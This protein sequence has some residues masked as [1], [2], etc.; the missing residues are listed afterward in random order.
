MLRI[1]PNI[2]TW[3]G[4]LDHAQGD[5]RVPPVIQSP[6]CQTSWLEAQQ[7]LIPSK[8]RVCVREANMVSAS[9]AICCRTAS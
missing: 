8:F 1:W 9:G 7:H 4:D 2:S 5:T 6:Y 3:V